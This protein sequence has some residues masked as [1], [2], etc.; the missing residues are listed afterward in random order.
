MKAA[1]YEHE[2]EDEEGEEVKAA[3]LDEL[4]PSRI[5]PSGDKPDSGPV[6]NATLASVGGQDTRNAPPSD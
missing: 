6:Q 1:S 4:H 2:E 5:G 3:S